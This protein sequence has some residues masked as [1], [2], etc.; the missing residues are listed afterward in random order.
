MPFVLG[1]ASLLPACLDSAVD[2]PGPAEVLDSGPGTLAETPASPRL[3]ATGYIPLYRFEGQWDPSTGALT[4]R[5]LEP[6]HAGRVL[7]SGL[8][9]AEQAL[10]WCGLAVDVDGTVGT[11]APNTFELVTEPG[12]ILT[13]EAC[14]GGAYSGPF[15]VFYQDQGAL[16]ADVTVRSF[17]NRLIDRV[18]A[19]IDDVDPDTENVAPYRFPLGT[20]AQAPTDGQNPPSDATGLWFYGDMGLPD[21]QI[22]N[23]DPVRPDEITRQWIFR[24]DGTPFTFRGTLLAAFT[25]DCT[26][27]EDD[28][29]N[30][31]ANELCG[32]YPLAAACED[33]LDCESGNCDGATLRCG[34]TTCETGV[35]DG[36]ETDVDCGGFCTPCALGQACLVNADCQS[37]ACNGGIC[38]AE[39]WPVPNSVVIT[40]VM[41]NP[42]GND[43]NREWFEVYNPGS[44][45]RQLQGCVFEDDRTVPDRFTVLSSV[46]IPPGGYVVFGAVR[47]PAINGG[48]FDGGFPVDYEY[49]NMAFGNSNDDV[50]RLTCGGNFIDRYL[51]TAANQLEGVA[52]NLSSTILISGAQNN[53]A[54][55]CPSLAPPGTAGVT[56]RGTPG[57]LN[58]SCFP[59]GPTPSQVGQILVTEVMGYEPS[60]ESNFEWFEL[61][62]RTSQEFDLGGCVIRED[63]ASNN[64]P[65]P[66]GTV[67]QPGQ[68]LLFAGQAELDGVPVNFS[69]NR[70]GAVQLNNTSDSVRLDCG[71][72]VIGRLNYNVTTLGLVRGQ[73]AQLPASVVAAG[74]AN[75]SEMNAAIAQVCAS[76]LTPSSRYGTRRLLGTPGQPNVG[77]DPV[78]M[79]PDVCFVTPGTQTAAT[80]GG[81]VE[82]QVHFD[83]AGVTGASTGN[84]FVPG[85]QNLVQLGTVA[86]GADPRLVA[87]TLVQVENAAAV[88]GWVAPVATPALDAF[89]ASLATP[90]SAGASYSVFGRVSRDG[91]ATWTWCDTVQGPRGTFAPAQQATITSGSIT[92]PAVTNCFF[93]ADCV[94]QLNCP[95]TPAGFRAPFVVNAF[96][97]PFAQA[98]AVEFRCGVSPTGNPGA[99]P[100][101]YTFSGA[102]APGSTDALSGAASLQTAACP[103]PGGLSG[104]FGF[105]TQARVAGGP[106]V[107]CSNLASEPFTVVNLG[108]PSLTLLPSSPAATTTVT[109]GQI[110]LF[111]GTVVPLNW[112]FANLG[113]LF[114]Q[115]YP[116]TV[117]VGTRVQWGI[118]NGDVSLA[119]AVWI[120]VTPEALTTDRYPVSATFQSPTPTARR[121]AWRY[122]ND[123]GASWT[124]VDQSSG[125]QPLRIVVEA[126]ATT[127]HP[128]INE[129]RTR[130]PGTTSS[131]TNE[132]TD[133]F[134]EIHNP[135]PDAINLDGWVL[136]RFGPNTTSTTGE[137]KAVFTAAHSIA[138][139][140]YLVVHH[141]N[142]TGLTGAGF[143][144]YGPDAGGMGDSGALVLREG[145]T[146][147]DA[148]TFGPVTAGAS[149]AQRAE[150][151]ALAAYLVDTSFGGFSLGRN[152][153]SVDTNN[154]A[155][156]FTL[157]AVPSPGQPNGSCDVVINEF[158][159]RGGA[160]AADEFI[161][162]HNT[163]SAPVRLDGWAVR[164]ATNSGTVNS[165]L[166]LAAPGLSANRVIAAQGYLVMVNTG[167]GA[168]TTAATADANGWLR[169]TTA[170]SDNA[171]GLVLPAPFGCDGGAPCSGV[172]ASA[173]T[174]YCWGDRVAISDNGVNAAMGEGSRVTG[175]PGSNVEHSIRRCP[176]G[177]DTNNNT[178]DFIVVSG[179]TSPNLTALPLT[180]GGANACP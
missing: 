131:K 144:P 50:V 94:D 1:A 66:F 166:N 121:W 161:E 162:L 56:G 109:T 10:A 107:D 110:A 11:G 90:A 124:V 16:C 149:A 133:E 75:E 134:I 171:L 151:T 101:L 84:D 163:C 150:G 170:I 126:P 19:Q 65:I 55:R 17:R 73:S 40:E 135:C 125:G 68:Y 2:A 155:A 118:S 156:D 32:Q 80:L 36:L 160:S 139:G 43:D 83:I 130:G 93:S 52:E 137:L 39:P 96:V 145:S 105:R 91:G 67:I 100:A 180:V 72:T 8:A 41:V 148:V 115:P 119:D 165:P 51:Y 26:T 147:R 114:Q 47:N 142:Y 62:N 7:E 24:Y 141:A 106:W 138:A 48:R 159:T 71:G 86:P 74:Y 42:F 64:L 97:S 59:S 35:K 95:T 127:C 31:R 63:S 18:Y 146:V 13:N 169:W 104:T 157:W 57:G 22:G 164:S 153:T 21:G 172:C 143:V 20:G 112:F 82:V 46:V 98:S 167:S 132:A 34:P 154:N 129:F 45:A 177:M 60:G 37:N 9:T 108:P 28:N 27:P 4:F 53:P 87:T 76:P 128:V 12:T 136:E 33:N 49:P 168:F 14:F 158:R 3:P 175:A 103:A 174:A 25:E 99:S 88:P 6:T 117:P 173:P 77:C 120:D 61:Y 79:P 54:N 69:Y 78:P 29:C 70:G 92:A 152:E 58:T 89:Q 116:A 15:A 102:T 44:V 81:S 179:S 5:T 111:E 38:F 178:V 30:G 176:N 113:S 23:P 123:N 140:G 85:G 122:S